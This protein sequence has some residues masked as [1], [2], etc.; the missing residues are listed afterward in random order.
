M[1]VGRAH[2]HLAKILRSLGQQLEEVERHENAGLD[3]LRGLPIKM[4]D[5]VQ[6]ADDLVTVFDSIHG[7]SEGR[8][9]SRKL[10]P[11]IQMDETKRQLA[12]TVPSEID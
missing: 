9:T 7:F 12:A 8:F 4:R 10:L 2:V 1:S 6:H 5:Y 3:I 11:I